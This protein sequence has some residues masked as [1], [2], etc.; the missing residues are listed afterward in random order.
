MSSL[1]MFSITL[2]RNSFQQ[3]RRRA[4]GPAENM[5][6][7]GLHAVD[8]RQESFYRGGMFWA[9]KLFRGEIAA[10]PNPETLG[11]NGFG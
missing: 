11:R 7:G 9:S 1:R 3:T 4:T 2:Q 8:E 6:V 5:E 10:F